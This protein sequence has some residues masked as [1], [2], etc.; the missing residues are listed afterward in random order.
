MMRIENLSSQYQTI[1]GPVVTVKDVS[2]D[3]KDNE[4]FGIAGESG[5]G[6]S[7]LLK[8]L[9]DDLTYPLELKSGKV[10]FEYSDKD[11]SRKTLESGCIHD[12]WWNEISY[13]P[14]AAMSVLNP[15][16]RIE[17]Q[18]Y[19]LY[20]RHRKKEKHAIV[21]KYVADYLSELDLPADILKSYP[22]QL[23]GGMRQRVVIAM[24]TFLQPSMI[25]ADEPT[26]A[27]D[28]VVRKSILMMLMDLQRKMKNTLVIVTHDM[29]VHYQIT[30]RMAIMYSGSI[31]ELGPTEDIFNDPLHPYTKMLIGSLPKIGSKEQRVGIT[32]GPPSFRNPPAGCRF[33]PRCRFA[34]PECSQSVPKLTEISPGR[35][36]ACSLLN[37]Q[38]GTGNG[39]KSS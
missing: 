8:V 10:I 11:G 38:G 37:G 4:I 39:D 17:D 7:T 20:V 21:N 25:L 18:F 14:Q 1:T 28:V 2:F 35:F 15:V 30:N 31:V 24:A 5:C 36:A 23:S 27:L 22:H 34:R 6:K 9:Y 29:G 13:I 32:G 3:I 26:T 33:A 16:Y 19:E 12:G